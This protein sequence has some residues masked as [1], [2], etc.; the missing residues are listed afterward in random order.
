[1]Q[2]QDGRLTVFRHL[3]ESSYEYAFELNRLRNLKYFNQRE[4]TRADVSLEGFY[5][6]TIFPQLITIEAG[7]LNSAADNLQ[8]EKLNITFLQVNQNAKCD[9]DYFQMR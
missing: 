8:Q 3:S 5:K 6:N 9:D 1:M 4:N 7:N 2:N